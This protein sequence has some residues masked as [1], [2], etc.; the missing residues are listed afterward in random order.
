MT[1]KQKIRIKTILYILLHFSWVLVFFVPFSWT[2]LFVGLGYYFVRMFAIT[3]G[4]HRY[5]SHRTFQTNRVFQFIL[6]LFGVFAIQNGPLWWASHHRLHHRYS[7]GEKD[8]HSPEQKGFWWSHVGWVLS[9]QFEETQWNKIKD[10]AKYPELRFLNKYASEIGMLPI[11]PFFLIGGWTAVVWGFFVSTVLLYHGTFSINSLSHMWGF[12]RFKITDESRNNPILA[13]ITLGEGW[14]NNHHRFAHS[15]RQGMY[16]W[17]YDVSFYILKVLSWF[18]IVWDMKSYPKSL[19]QE[20]RQNKQDKKSDV[21]VDL[22][23]Q[24]PV[25]I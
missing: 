15:A 1:Q 19:Y 6:A 3:A 21:P 5:F 17:E 10:F 24:K 8:I 12:K 16:W 13:I 4:Y 23:P 7:G 22:A 20:A 25:A 14:H 11:I 18:G 9:E 2:W